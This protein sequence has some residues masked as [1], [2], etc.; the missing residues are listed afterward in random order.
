MSADDVVINV[1]PLFHI[2][3]LEFATHLTWLAEGCIWI[4][5]N[6]DIPR[7]LAALQKGTVFMAV[8]AIYMRLLED[9]SFS[10]SRRNLAQHSPLHMRLGTDSSGSTART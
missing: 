2:H 7:T 9:A 3:G 6:F 10:R 5:D 1:L 8:P 4:E